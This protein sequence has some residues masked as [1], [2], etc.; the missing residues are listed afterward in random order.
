MMRK[1]FEIAVL[2]ASL[3]MASELPFHYEFSDF[4]RHL[5]KGEIDPFEIEGPF[6]P[7]QIPDNQMQQ[8]KAG[9]FIIS[10]LT[11]AV[12]YGLMSGANDARRTEPL[13][14]YL[15]WA[16]PASIAVLLGSVG[17]CVY[18]DRK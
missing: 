18:R 10:E 11:E 14:L 5:K 3:A 6:E 4:H 16:I 12:G 9:K 7:S 13:T 8:L 17:Y 1:T 2:G 15:Y